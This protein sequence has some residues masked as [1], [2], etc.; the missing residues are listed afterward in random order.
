MALSTLDFFSFSLALFIIF[1]GLDPEKSERITVQQKNGKKKKIERKLKPKKKERRASTAVLLGCMGFCLD[2]RRRRR[3]D[4]RIEERG[5][6]CAVITAFRSQYASKQQQIPNSCLFSM[7]RK[8]FSYY[9]V[10]IG[11]S[12]GKLITCREDKTWQCFQ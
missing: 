8:R 2:R 6:S 7:K 12:S 4:L 1:V 10:Y 5:V 11:G 3:R 9:W